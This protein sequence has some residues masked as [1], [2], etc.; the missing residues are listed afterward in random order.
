MY[1]LGLF[2]HPPSRE[3]ILIFTSGPNESNTK[4]LHEA[5]KMTILAPCVEIPLGR[6]KVI[7]ITDE[8]KPARLRLERYSLVLFG[9]MPS[10]GFSIM[11]TLGPKESNK[12]VP[13][14]AMIM[15][16]LDPCV[17]IPTRRLKLIFI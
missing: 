3:F 7:F 8:A 15:T 6:S 1:S 2:A 4:T 13:H 16:I 9:K 12:K 5:L 11:F 17:E 10:R 14:E